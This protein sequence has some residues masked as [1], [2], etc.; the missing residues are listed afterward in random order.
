MIDPVMLL[1]VMRPPGLSVERLTRQP[2]TSV[3]RSEV[4]SW[5]RTQRGIMFIV[6]YINILR[7]DAAAEHLGGAQ[8]SGVRPSDYTTDV[9]TH[10]DARARHC[11]GCHLPYLHGAAPTVSTIPGYVNWSK[12]ET[13]SRAEPGPGAGPRPTEPGP[14]ATW[15]GTGV[16]V[17]R[18]GRGKEGETGMGEVRWCHVE[19]GP[20]GPTEV[21]T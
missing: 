11:T 12:G 6:F 10:G 16:R 18:E 20:G 9:Y 17:K 21:A 19:P 4:A 15:G 2:N 8:R 3:A 14:V 1:R 5:G 7:W 13:V